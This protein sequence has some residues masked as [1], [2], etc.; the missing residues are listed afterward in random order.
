MTFFRIFRTAPAPRAQ[1]TSEHPK[2]SISFCES[3]PQFSRDKSPARQ[4]EFLKGHAL[5][6]CSIA[7]TPPV[8]PCP[9]PLHPCVYPSA[10]SPF[11]RRTP[12]HLRALARTNPNLFPATFPNVTS[13]ATAAPP[14]LLTQS[15]LAVVSSEPKLTLAPR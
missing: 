1:S 11:P 9:T 3:Y 15:L 5:A 8:L 2:Q 10:S 13:L 12:S 4:K 6:S 7:A 14:L